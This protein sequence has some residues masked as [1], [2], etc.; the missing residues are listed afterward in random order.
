MKQMEKQLL[1]RPA[2]CVLFRSQL[3]ELPWQVGLDKVPGGFYMSISLYLKS[4]K[5]NCKSSPFVPLSYKIEVQQKSRR[6]GFWALL[7]SRQK[8]NNNYFP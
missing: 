1:P 7:D 3:L 8:L 2:V 5:I 6:I 4:K